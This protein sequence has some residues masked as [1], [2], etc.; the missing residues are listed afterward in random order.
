MVW[1]GSRWVRGS[2]VKISVYGSVNPYAGGWRKPLISVEESVLHVKRWGRTYR[3]HSAIGGERR[4][5]ILLISF[6]ARLAE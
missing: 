6:E 3:E 2:V 5:L 1:L 4:R